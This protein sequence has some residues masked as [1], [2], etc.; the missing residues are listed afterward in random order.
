MRNGPMIAALRSFVL[1]CALFAAPAFGQA[2]YAPGGIAVGGT[3]VVAY[4]REGKAVPGAPAHTHEFQGAVWRFSSAENRAAFAA[5]PERY[6]PQYGGFC[7]W[8]VAQGYRAEIDPEAWRIVGDKLYLNY[9]RVIRARWA[10]SRIRS[11]TVHPTSEA[12]CS[13]TA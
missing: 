9:S 13:T 7:A 10:G 12:I 1:V 2:V 5:E 3:D 11:P 6:A 4:F 8:A